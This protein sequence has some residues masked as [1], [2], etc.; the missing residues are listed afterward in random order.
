MAA[1]GPD[2][3]TDVVVKRRLLVLSFHAPPEMAVGG[4]RWAGLT[5]HLADRGWDIRVITAS[6]GAAAV[7]Q[8]D[9]LSVHEVP[10]RTTLGDRY[11]RWK[12]TRSGKKGA[13]V[14]AYGLIGT[15]NG[16]PGMAPRQIGAVRLARSELGALLS[17]PDHGRGWV[18]RAA[19]ATRQSIHEWAPDVVV[20]TGPP[21]SVHLAAR[22]GL[23]RSGTPW[24]VDLRDPWAT[25]EGLLADTGWSAAVARR[26]EA[27]VFRRASTILTTT[28]ELQEVVQRHFPA[29]APAWLPNGVDM[30]DLPPRVAASH[31]GLSICHVGTVYYNR[32]PTPVLRAFASFLSA[33]PAA[34]SAGSRLRFVG[35][36][37]GDFRRA[38]DQRVHDLGIAPHV[39]VTGAVPRER[40][41]EILATSRMALVLAQGQGIMVPAK[42]YEAVG[43]GLRTLVITE[44]DSATG[45]EGSR[46]GAAVHDPVDE[47]GMVATME[48]VWAGGRDTGGGITIPSRIDHAH[49]ASKLEDVLNSVCARPVAPV[50]DSA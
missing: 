3:A 19:R 39:E 38:L 10:R 32:D 49:L 4:L 47:A 34:A 30:R 5:R 50:L 17:F 11:R 6:P 36:V 18:L 45:R 25:P 8:P 1:P 40:A 37:S 7:I 26:M 12:L 24:V 23:G 13:G 21:H 27:S 42:L 48:E 15:A 43:L 46:L 20:S 29:T 41:L 28:P 16:R 35:Y 31:P 2:R 33:N 44:V 9:G 22:L 14:A